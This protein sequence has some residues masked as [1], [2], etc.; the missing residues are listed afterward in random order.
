MHGMRWVRYAFCVSVACATAT[1]AANPTPIPMSPHAML[2]LLPT[3]QSTTSA[4]ASSAIVNA[5]V[6]PSNTGAQIWNLKNA[7][8]RAVIQTISILTGKNFVI[9][10]RVQG[11][12]TLVS[13]K[14]M[15]PDEMY[16]VFLSMLQ[17]LQFSAIPS[18]DVIKIVPSN[19][20][21]AMTRQIATEDSPGTGEE[22]VVRVVP[23]QRVSATELV[24]VL[25]PLMP[26][27]GSISAYLPTNSLILAG[28]A[29]SITRLMAVIE[30]MDNENANQVSVIHLRY[31]NAKKVVSVIHALKSGNPQS[32]T[33]N[34]TLVADEEDNSILVNANATNQM[35][36]R[37][38]VKQL[39]LPG[40]GGDDTKVVPL[41]YLSAKKMAPILSKIAGG[42]DAAS[43][44]GIVST[45][46]AAGGAAK[47]ALDA[48][49]NSGSASIQAEED[50]NALIMHAPKAILSSLM[51]V[52]HQLDV[53]PQEVLVE[54]IIVKVDENLLNQLGIEWGSPNGPLGSA[55][56]STT[57]STGLASI[58]A[59]GAFSFK[60]GK[61]GVGLLPDGNMMALLHALKSNT[62]TDV[63]STPSIVVLNNDKAKIDDGQNVGVANRSYQNTPPP[64][65]ATPEITNAYNTIERQDVTLSLEVTPH[66]SPNSMIRLDLLQKDDT[67]ASTSNADP[68]NPT[69]NT[70]KIKTSVLVK[71]GDILVLGGLIT[72]EQDKTEN[73]LPILGNIPVLGHLFRYNTHKLDKM[74]LMVFIRPVVM[75][76]GTDKI[77]TTNRYGYV[78]HQQIEM[79]TESVN[80]YAKMNMLPQLGKRPSVNLP[81]IP[82][83]TSSLPPPTKTGEK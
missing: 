22:V 59:D 43:S 29:S 61:N 66:V 69:L 67:I 24:P 16:Q 68:D 42:M 72:N 49:S 65:G 83:P 56:S 17:L 63:L 74:S 82:V 7:D 31:A 12:I 38:L 32:G 35:L 40:A 6:K 20:A 26:Q 8:I 30:Q 3:A 10:P 18:G 44:G 5:A 78:R 21:N 1:L 70:S 62:S 19:E 41:N 55:I 75:S 60:V 64:A 4:S 28:T 33:M 27:S 39:D 77:Q 15:T 45:G 2:P 53:R 58:G 37:Q 34:V 81:S 57:G 23:V 25:R 73:K 11:N 71:S 13:Q 36:T 54:A 50:N 51:R 46:G 76:K 79:E 14:P 48:A 47:G 80:D 9:D 52:I